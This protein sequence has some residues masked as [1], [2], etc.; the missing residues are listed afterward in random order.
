MGTT[1]NHGQNNRFPG[2]IL[3]KNTGH[4]F[5]WLQTCSVRGLLLKP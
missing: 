1:R 3:N 5:Y 4:N 2:S